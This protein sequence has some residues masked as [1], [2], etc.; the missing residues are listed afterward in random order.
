MS[1]GYRVGV[2][3]ATGLVGTTILELL[4]AREFPVAELRLL[5]SERSAGKTVVCHA[6]LKGEHI[7]VSEADGTTLMTDRFFVAAPFG[8]LGRLAMR[9][10]LA[11]YLR[12]LL[13][14][15]AAH[16]KSMAEQ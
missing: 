11:Q 16:I 15:R 14:Q 8:A 12:R 10:G 7:F 2:L 4:A 3:G 6:D 13:L 1:D 5:A 9:A